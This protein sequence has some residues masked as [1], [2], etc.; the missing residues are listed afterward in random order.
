[1]ESPVI[2]K[3]FSQVQASES[4]SRPTGLSSV[5]LSG[6]EPGGHQFPLTCVADSL[7]GTS[8]RLTT[9]WKVLRR[10]VGEASCINTPPNI[11][12]PS[13]F[14][15]TV[16]CVKHRTSIWGKTSH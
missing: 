14:L 2:R 10:V 6:S 12:G 1:M 11:R 7:S 5:T 15:P 13:R 3:L 8:G 4:C 9:A 16:A